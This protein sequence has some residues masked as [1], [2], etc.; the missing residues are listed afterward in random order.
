MS[1]VTQVRFSE[2][3]RRQIQC[4][5]PFLRFTGVQLF[6][7]SVFPHSVVCKL[8]LLPP[9]VPDHCSPVD[10]TERSGEALHTYNPE[11]L[12]P[13]VSVPTIC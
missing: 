8:T 3:R 5:R 12:A 9:A 11:I 10:T 13:N 1:C 2:D 7:L 6:A 4:N